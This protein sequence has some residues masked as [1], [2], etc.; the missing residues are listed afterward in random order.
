[1]EDD[2]WQ[3]SPYTMIKMTVLQKYVTVLTI[4]A[5]NNTASK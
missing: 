5:P 2:Q 1:M 3:R 4:Y